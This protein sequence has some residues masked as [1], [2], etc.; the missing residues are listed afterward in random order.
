[1]LGTWISSVTWDEIKQQLKNTGSEDQ[2]S[3]LTHRLISDVPKENPGL[4]T[5]QVAPFFPGPTLNSVVLS[6]SVHFKKS[7]LFSR[8]TARKWFFPSGPV[9]PL[10]SVLLKGA[11]QQMAR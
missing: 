4:M 2:G 11:L 5:T 3:D 10:L 8:L 6:E 7:V 9:I 1:M